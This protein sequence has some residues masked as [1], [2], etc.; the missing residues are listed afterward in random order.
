MA[1]IACQDGGDIT[2][3]EIIQS[4]RSSRRPV[5]IEVGMETAR[6][7][8]GDDGWK[9]ITTGVKTNPDGTVKATYI[10]EGEI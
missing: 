2:S 5:A 6:I 3:N 4:L 1:F 9:T 8:H 10:F 7:P